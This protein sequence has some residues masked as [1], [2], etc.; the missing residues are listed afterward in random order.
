ME[1]LLTLFAML[2][3]V[4]GAVNGVRGEEMRIHQAEAAVAVEAAVGVRQAQV[5]GVARVPAR[6]VPSPGAPASP[7][8]AVVAA[9]PL[10]AVRLIE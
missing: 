10:E 2:G 9:A 8:P 3:A 6:A 1:L 7:G 5:A 4:T